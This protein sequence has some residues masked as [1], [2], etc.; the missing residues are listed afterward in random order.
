MT[1]V[2]LEPPIWIFRIPLNR[3]EMAAA[4]GQKDPWPLTHENPL[5]LLEKLELIS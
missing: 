2:G 3:P 1:T 4:H 5:I